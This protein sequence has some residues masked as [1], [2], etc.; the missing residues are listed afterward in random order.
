[1]S[2][3]HTDGSKPIGLATTTISFNTITYTVI[4]Y[5][6]V[7]PPVTTT[8]MLDAEGQPEGSFGQTGLV[9]T[10]FTLQVPATETTKLA[11]GVAS[12]ATYDGVTWITTNVK[13]EQEAGKQRFIEVE[14]VKKYN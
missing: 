1:M 4:K 10:T 12:D 5:G 11:N 13:R 14:C 3:S 8:P 6:G 2:L 7:T 9:T